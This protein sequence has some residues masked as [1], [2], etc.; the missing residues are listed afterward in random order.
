MIKNN[1]QK[2][3]KKMIKNSLLN[4]K[5][6]SL[7]TIFAIILTCIMLT[8]VFTISMSML[9]SMEHT[10]AM[11]VGSS[12]HGGFKFLTEDQVDELKDHHLIKSYGVST[13]IGLIEDKRLIR[14]SIEIRTMD[15]NYM[16]DSFVEVEGSFPQNRDEIIL[17]TMTLNLL[18]LP[19]ELNQEVTLSMSIGNKPVTESFEIVGI[20]ESNI[21]SHTS[22]MIT[23]DEFKNS[24][25]GDEIGPN[26]LGANNL[27]V[28][29]V[30]KYNIKSK[31][32]TII[33]DYGYTE[34][35]INSGVN[36][37]YVSDITSIQPNDLFAYVL[38]IVMLMLSG[39]LIIYNIYLI[40]INKDINHYG[41]LK[42]IG[43]TQKQL[44]QL[45]YGQALRLYIVSLPIGLLLGYIIGI[46]LVPIILNTLN[47]LTVKTSA[48]YSIFIFAALLTGVTVFISCRKPAKIASKVSPLE[49]VRSVDTNYK[50]SRKN[51]K[52]KSGNKLHLM[53]WTNLFRVRKKAVLVILSLTLSLLILSS[54][55]ISVENFD[56]EEFLSG[57]IGSD[58]LI[59]N[60]EY[61]TYRNDGGTI[62]DSFL[63]EISDIGVEVHSFT[64]FEHLI[65]V[66]DELRDKIVVNDMA[67]DQSSS[68]DRDYIKIE[69]YGI[70]A[71]ILNRLN[72]YVV[73]GD[74]PKVLKVNQIIV[75]S[76]FFASDGFAHAPY[77][78]GDS[79]E[80]NNQSYE[81]VAF[82][83]NIPLYLYDQSF[84][85]YSIQAFTMEESSS[86][87][88]TLMV[89][90]DLEGIKD[91]LLKKYPKLVIKSR[92]DYIKHLEGYI[93]MVKV[94]GYTLSGILAAIGVLNFIN[95]TSTSIIIR[96]REFAIMASI[97]MTG[98]QLSKMLY[99]EGLYVIM[100]S[101][102]L[103]SIL[104]IPIS[105]LI[106]G[107]LILSHAMTMIL[108]SL[109]YIIIISLIPRFS[110]KIMSNE[111]IV[112]RLSVVE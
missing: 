86:D 68:F 29:F 53:A 85:Q 28:S 97:G 2:I 38:M 81:I 31:L 4:H 94:V 49:A 98:K 95:M 48:H 55:L 78:I 8:S 73:K 64:M 18:D 67:E 80:F 9:K 27:A 58:Y 20:Y 104:S 21:Y 36:W 19:H 112:E 84:T 105:F 111:S 87:A 75:D 83:D 22:Y 15:S 99:F 17:D 30:S 96:K 108:L 1:N 93:R 109:C 50:Y 25:V 102:G 32:L 35:E 107:R 70:D 16:K 89:N 26:M 90:G 63:D 34:E 7:M 59:G 33:N 61:F 91:D 6:R 37:A 44:K 40:S 92:Y 51:K 79:I 82:V 10:T 46:L 57:V 5:A 76:R 71:F 23:S 54:V 65:E 43:A 3:M 100:L 12:A 47:I 72:D 106:A 101:L 52:R 74:I 14:R 62:P 56:P 103:M 69:S 66:T 42:T 45:I 39:Y 60:A 11:Q 110:Y 24:F 77:E 41:L 13:V 88:M